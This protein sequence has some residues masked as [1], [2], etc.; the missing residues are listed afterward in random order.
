MHVI[1]LWNLNNARDE[2]K[3]AQIVLKEYFGGVF[4]V[5]CIRYSSV[6]MDPSL[7]HSV[8]TKKV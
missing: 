2:N 8:L 3:Q 5:G 7:S 1:R 4:E 6:V